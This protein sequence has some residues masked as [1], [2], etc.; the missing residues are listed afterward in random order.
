LWR[1]QVQS[2]RVEQPN[3]L[4]QGR[5]RQLKMAPDYVV[6]HLWHAKRNIKPSSMLSFHAHKTGRT[7]RDQ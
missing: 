2:L 1:H 6:T 5:I 3:H 4:W 7:C